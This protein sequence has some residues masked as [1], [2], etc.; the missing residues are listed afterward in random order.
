MTVV[1]GVSPLLRPDE[2]CAVCQ[3]N[4]DPL[5]TQNYF[6]ANCNHVFHRDCLAK[7]IM[8]SNGSC[9]YCKDSMP[10]TVDDM[11]LSKEEKDEFAPSESGA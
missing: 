5:E 1:N 2:L 3:Y 11:E 10:I 7:W 4:I 8:R 9:P 6:R